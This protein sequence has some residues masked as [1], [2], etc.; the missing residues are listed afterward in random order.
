MTTTNYDGPVS[1]LVCSV[2][3]CVGATA[4]VSAETFEPVLAQRENEVMVEA[5]IWYFHGKK[6]WEIKF[7]HT[8]C[9]KL[10]R[11]AQRSTFLY[12]F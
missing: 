2:T 9:L 12:F 8:H 11:E 10:T 5:C 3:G 6:G 1:I 4:C 7:A